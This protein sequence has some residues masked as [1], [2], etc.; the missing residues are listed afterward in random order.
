MI[1]YIYLP[2]FTNGQ[3]VHI[4]NDET[5]RVYSQQPYQ[6]STISYTDYF[7][8]SH[9]MSQPG[10]QYFN[11]YST[12]PSCLDSNRI[13]TDFYYRNDLFEI[14]AIFL[15]ILIIAF[16]IPFKIV[17]RFFKRFR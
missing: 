11:Q 8:D 10:E 16:G 13:T 6:N 12:I 4:Q 9:Y 7:I 17:T 14:L 3:C 5:I 1:E 2:Q 15:I